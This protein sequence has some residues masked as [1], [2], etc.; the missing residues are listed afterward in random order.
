MK[1]AADKTGSIYMGS[2][3]AISAIKTGITVMVKPARSPIEV[4]SVIV[5]SEYVMWMVSTETTP[6]TERFSQPEPLREEPG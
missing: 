5:K 3:I 4:A 2:G 1:F 6:A